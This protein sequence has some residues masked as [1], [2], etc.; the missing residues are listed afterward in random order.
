MYAKHL[1]LG[2]SSR[3]RLLQPF[4]VLLL[5]LLS[6]VRHFTDSLHSRMHDVLAASAPLWTE[7]SHSR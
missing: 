4:I 2:S 3:Q 6:S 7:A 1:S 5:I